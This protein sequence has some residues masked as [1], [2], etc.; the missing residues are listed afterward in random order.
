MNR[1]KGCIVQATGYSIG[2]AAGAVIALSAAA[3]GCEDS[4][5]DL[6]REVSRL[7]EELAAQ[8]ARIDG[9]VDRL[10]RLEALASSQDG[11]ETI[12][13]EDV[14]APAA[15]PAI[16]DQTAPDLAALAVSV[17]RRT[18]SVG[19]RRYSKKKL[20]DRFRTHA[21][22]NPRA[23]VILRVASG[24]SSRRITEIG[25]IAK[26]QGITQIAVVR[27]GTAKDKKRNRK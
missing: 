11:D 7:R 21:E 6:V 27:E 26:K 24:V 14:P 5:Q 4:N 17:G 13:R 9:I 19:N 8:R 23:A 22:N 3:M 20:G 1:V 18:I 2:L 15:T 10:D 16:A 12:T 25:D